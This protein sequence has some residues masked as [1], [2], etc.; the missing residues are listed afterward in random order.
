M[1]AGPAGRAG[2]ATQDLFYSDNPYNSTQ[3][4]VD[5]ANPAYTGS[6]SALPLQTVLVRVNN[7]AT[8][9]RVRT[10]L[11]I[12]TPPQVRPGPAWRRPRRGRSARRSR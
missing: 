1:R 12:N 11:A 10:Y 7:P 3:P 8:L 6:L 2:P 5:A 4:F 9:E